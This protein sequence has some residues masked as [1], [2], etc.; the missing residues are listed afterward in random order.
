MADLEQRVDKL[1]EK[2]RQLEID[3]NRSLSD[4]KSSLVEIKAT[5]TDSKDSG[6]LKN[7]LIE[8][9]VVRNTERIKELEGNQNKMVWAIVLEFLALIFA[10]IRYYLSNGGI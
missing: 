4:I 6:D 1:E 10:V 2:V 9:N 3:I 8:Q 7:Q 5:L